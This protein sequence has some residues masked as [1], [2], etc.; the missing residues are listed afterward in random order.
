M[1]EHLTRAREILRA[2]LG[3]HV[4]EARR[5]D[6]ARATV[7]ELAD[8]ATLRVMLT[9][10]ATGTETTAACARRSYRDTLGCRWRLLLIDG[11]YSCTLRL[12]AWRAAGPQERLDIHNHRS[13]LASAVVRGELRSDLYVPQGPGDGCVDGGLTVTAY[14]EQLSADGADWLLVPLGPSRLRLVHTVRYVAGASYA[15]GPLALH[16]AWC[17]PG[18]DA[19]TL[20]LETGTERRPH[21]D[22]YSTVDRHAMAV[23]K[24]ALT[25]R[26]FRSVLTTLAASLTDTAPT[27]D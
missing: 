5:L 4:P 21:T 20:F 17:D 10:L 13:A 1:G 11:G 25:E 3:G 27:Q 8:A 23:H 15:L 7:A 16:R 12:H 9:E 24:A 18:R 19:L 6:V 14:R 22:V 2:R 26:E